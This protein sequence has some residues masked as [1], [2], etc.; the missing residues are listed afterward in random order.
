MKT[1]TK[2]KEVIVIVELWAEDKIITHREVS[3]LIPSKRPINYRQVVDATQRA[4]ANCVE[5]L[6]NN[7]DNQ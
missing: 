7:L 4:V 5:L 2:I 6:K 3:V 1:Q